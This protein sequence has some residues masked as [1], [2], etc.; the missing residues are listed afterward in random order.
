MLTSLA[1]CG[2][3]RKTLL[4]IFLSSAGI[5]AR[6]VA[7]ARATATPLRAP[8]PHP[9]FFSI[10]CRRDNTSGAIE[11]NDS[12][13]N[14][15]LSYDGPVSNVESGGEQAVSTR[16]WYLQ[17][18]TPQLDPNPLLKR[19]QLPELPPDPP[20]LLEW[21]LEHISTDLG[22]D[23]LT[24]YDLRQLDPP[25]ALGANLIMIIGTARSEKHL[26][27]S[28]DRFC[29]WLK[30]SH[31]LSPYAD[32]LLG[33]G[34]LK[35]KLRRK[36]RRARLLS[37]VGSSEKVNADDGIRTGWICVNV[38]NVPDG[39]KSMVYKDLHEDYV[40]F[41]EEI[42]GAKVVIQML[43]Q[44]KREELDLEDLWGKSVRR[45]ERKEARMSATEESN[46]APHQVGNQSTAS[47]PALSDIQFAAASRQGLSLGSYAQARSYHTDVTVAATSPGDFDYQRADGITET[48]EEAEEHEGP[49]TLNAE[50][51]PQIISSN[52]DRLAH[53]QQQAHHLMALP[54]IQAKKMLREDNSPF[55]ESFDKIYPLFPALQ[56][57]EIKLDVLAYRQTLCPDTGK[58]AAVQA[59]HEIASSFIDIPVRMYTTILRTLMQAPVLPADVFEAASLIEQSCARGHDMGNEWIRAAMQQ[60]ILQLP[61]APF[62]PR[63]R[64]DAFE[65]FRVVMKRM[66]GP[67]SVATELEMLQTCAQVGKWREFW[68]I[69]RS[70]PRAMRPR[71]KELYVAMFHHVAARHHQAEAIRCVREHVPEMTLEEPSVT[72]DAEIAL[73]VKACLLVAE[74]EIAR[75]AA[76][77]DAFGEW[78]SLWRQCNRTMTQAGAK[79]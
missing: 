66:M 42:D 18:G 3:C 57:A 56:E 19:Q 58:D 52:Q 68:D 15:R 73:A 71:P 51:D 69:W 10:S 37:K 5:P 13:H 60:A 11:G 36:A 50:Q 33:R 2:S 77:E 41:G 4:D 49:Q 46:D 22:L 30:T 45:H 8:P 25:P 28:A 54:Q 12:A 79:I 62:A 67:A 17:V 55:W 27:V 44:E 43:T 78:V 74:P 48:A 76:Q 53:L 23:D 75:M 1:R 34:E 9:R 64:P 47:K 72:W 14:G 16:P 39:R 63:F 35:L 59:F 6:T 32:G 29:R 20:P 61:D 70:F 26:H 40:G 7:R 31:K 38:G 21:M 24:L 65:R